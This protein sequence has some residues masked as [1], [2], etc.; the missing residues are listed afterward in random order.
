MS[1]PPAN[2][3]LCFTCSISSINQMMTRIH[4]FYVYQTRATVCCRVMPANALFH[5]VGNKLLCPDY[6]MPRALLPR[7]HHYHSRN[8]MPTLFIFWFFMW[9]IIFNGGE[10]RVVNRKEGRGAIKAEKFCLL[11]EISSSGQFWPSRAYC[12]WNRGVTVNKTTL[13]ML[14]CKNIQHKP[15]H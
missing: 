3:Y 12:R 13:Y 1:H 9:T 7:H 11:S 6:V 15:V 5:A 10:I 14:E 2:L 8:T 4:W